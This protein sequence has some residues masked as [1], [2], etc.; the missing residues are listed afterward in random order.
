MTHPDHGPGYLLPPDCRD[1]D[2]ER[3]ETTVLRLCFFAF[4]YVWYVVWLL[5]LALAQGWVRPEFFGLRP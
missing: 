1:L 2:R 3:M 4:V 5:M